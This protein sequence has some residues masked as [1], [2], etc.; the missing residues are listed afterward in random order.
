MHVGPRQQRR[1]AALATMERMDEEA[2]ESFPASDPP[3]RTAITEE[4]RR[5]G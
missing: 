5:D 2:R 3:S 4:G 1:F